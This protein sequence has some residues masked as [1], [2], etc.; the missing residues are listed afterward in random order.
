MCLAL[1][2]R[3]LIALYG[4]NPFVSLSETY[5]LKLT[6]ASIVGILS[7]LFLYLV[8]V[9]QTVFLTRRGCSREPVSVGRLA[10][11]ENK[12]RLSEKS[13]V[14]NLMLIEFY[15]HIHEFG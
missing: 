4:P 1:E 12:K 14:D 7:H 10:S 11:G 15:S 13:Y 5:V 8:K 9:V 3:D 2:M 6:V